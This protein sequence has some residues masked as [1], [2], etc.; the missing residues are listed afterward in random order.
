MLVLHHLHWLCT[1]L[2]L[3]GPATA[4]HGL[5]AQDTGV[6]TDGLVHPSASRCSEI[7]LAVDG[8]LLIMMEAKRSFGL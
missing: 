4:S 1:W 3:E 5:P 7:S 2:S 8:L 6:E